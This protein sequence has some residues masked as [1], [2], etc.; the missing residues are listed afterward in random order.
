MEFKPN[1]NNNIQETIPPESLIILFLFASLG[2]SALIREINKKTGIPYA[3]M[4]FV[5]GI[6]VGKLA[7]NMGIIGES[8]NNIKNINPQGILM[9]FLPILIFESGFNSDWHS[10]KKQSGQIFLLVFPC[11]FLSALFILI[12]IKIILQYDDTYYSWKG[13][14]MFGSIL[15]CTDTVQILALLKEVGAI[16]KFKSLVEGESLLNYGTSIILYEIST[17]LFK[18]ENMNIFEILKLFFTLFFGGIFLGIFIGVIGQFWIKKIHNDPILTVNVTF[19]SCYLCY[20]FAENIDFGFQISGVMSLVSL[21]LF[22]SIFAKPKISLEEEK[23][24]LIF[25]KYVVFAA[26]SVIFLLAGI[27]IGVQVL[28]DSSLLYDINGQQINDKQTII[29]GD[30]FR[31][32]GLYFCM[33]F[34]RF[35]SITCVVRWLKKWGYGITWKEVYMLSFGGLRGAVGISFAII[36]ANDDYYPQKFRDIVLF[37]MA[38]NAI[39]SLIINGTITGPLIKGL[40]LCVNYNIREKVYLGFLQNLKLES[41]R[42]IQFLKGNSYLKMVNWNILKDL[43]GLE[44]FHLKIKQIQEE[45]QKREKEEALAKKLIGKNEIVQIEM[46]ENLFSTKDQQNLQQQYELLENS[47]NEESSEIQNLDKDKI[48]EARNRFLLALKGIYW[49]QYEKHQCSSS[50]LLLLL[51]SVNWDLDAQNESMNSWEFLYNYFHNP[52]YIQILFQLQVVP[53]FRNKTS[54]L[55][56]N[57][58]AFIYDVVTTYIEAHETVEEIQKEFPISDQIKGLISKESLNNRTSGHQ[59][60]VD[61]IKISFPEIKKQTQTKK[62]AFSLLEKQMKLIQ[63]SVRFG[64]IDDKQF[65]EQKKNIEQLQIQ[66][67]NIQPSW[68][69]PPKKQFLIEFVPFFQKIPEKILDKIIEQ[70]TEIIIEKDQYIIKEGQKAKFLYIITRGC[71]T[72]TCSKTFYTYNEKKTVSDVLFHYQLVLQNMRYVSSC[73]ADAVVY[74]LAFPLEPLQKVAKFNL[75]IEELVWQ[76]SLRGL[77]QMFYDQLQPLGN[78]NKQMCDEVIQNSF[79]KKYTSKQIIDCFNGGVLL[80]GIVKGRDIQNEFSFKFFKPGQICWCK[81]SLNNKFKPKQ[82]FQS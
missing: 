58:I 76:Q 24:V 8:I 80:K 6:I 62:A 21:G 20:F 16:K 26:E 11:V 42:K 9:I 5:M 31:L 35:A 14:F 15:S 72:E 29:F 54:N 77:S 64:H 78:L 65:L 18:N 13:A 2:L 69:L 48:I 53:F 71:A 59:Y 74:V 60:I 73:M 63:D 57:Q 4:L 40:G 23:V 56:F 44:D 22:L 33:L 52:Y 28:T 70:S 82:I 39:L 46:V 41:E 30:Y 43:V 7:D 50:T 12:S 49:I 36:V 38:G 32:F 67:E 61:Y 51:E 27:L 17:K 3:P 45:V 47:D 79:I 81:K 25:W 34:S 75:E 55:L 1:Q 68:K 37:D 66:L 10:F 19:I